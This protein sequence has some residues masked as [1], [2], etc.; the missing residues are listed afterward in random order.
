MK[1]SSPLPSSH[2]RTQLLSE[3]YGEVTGFSLIGGLIPWWIQGLMALLGS[4]GGSLAGR[5]LEECTW[6]FYFALVPSAFPFL[7]FLS[8]MREMSASATWQLPSSFTHAE[9]ELLGAV[10]N[11]NYNNQWTNRYTNLHLSAIDSLVCYLSLI[12]IAQTFD[13]VLPKKSHETIYV[14]ILALV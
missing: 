3:G 2:T 4:R 8:T 12:C 14:S 6:G 13:Y 5:L 9:V 10:S 1:C 7:C 11:T